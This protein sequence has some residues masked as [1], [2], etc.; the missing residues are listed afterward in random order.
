VNSYMTPRST[1]LDA[2]NAMLRATK[3]LYG[4]WSAEYQHVFECFDAINVK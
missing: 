1:Y 2:K 3:D 4:A